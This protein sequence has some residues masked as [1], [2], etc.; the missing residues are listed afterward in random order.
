MTPR[1]KPVW[2]FDLDNTLHDASYAIFPRI[3]R[4]MTEYV[5]RVLGSD[6]ATASRVRTEY[7]QRYGATLLG[8]VRHH[9]VDPADFLRE[10]HRFDDLTSLIRARRGL[11]KLLRALP[12]R[13]ILLTNA[14]RDYAG[15]VVRHLGIGRQF[16]RQVAIEQMWVHRRLRPKPDRLMMRRLLARERVPAH[17][18]VLV[19]DTLSHLKRYRG[20][21]LRTVWI[22][23]YLRQIHPSRPTA[24]ASADAAIPGAVTDA[25]VHAVLQQEAGIAMAPSVAADSVQDVAIEGAAPVNPGKRA[26]TPQSVPPARRILGRNRPGYVSVKVKSLDQLKRYSGL[27]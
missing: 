10:A 9:G 21:G 24:A 27:G 13:K 1:S 7:W 11:A 17:R 19:E 26:N 2:L 18:A 14:P 5:A 8:M 22:T 6:L 3:N 20:M 12:G 15:Q 23:G 16:S 25:V 4:G